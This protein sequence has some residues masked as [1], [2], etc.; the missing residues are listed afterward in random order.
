MTHI[1]H[2]AFPS[3][4][5]RTDVLRLYKQM[6]KK[7]PKHRK[8]IYFSGPLTSGGAKTIYLKPPKSELDSVDYIPLVIK[9]NALFFEIVALET[10]EFFSDHLITLPHHLGNRKDWHEFDYLR[11]WMYYIS[12]VTITLVEQFE[13]YLQTKEI[14]DLSIFNNYLAPRERRFE[15][16][17]KLLDVFMQYFSKNEYKSNPLS[18]MVNMPD[19][20][21]SLGSRFE[22]ELA[23]AFSIKREKIYFDRKHPHFASHIAKVSPWLETL[24]YTNPAV[25]SGNGTQLIHIK[26]I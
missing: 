9:H 3:N 1:K 20:E 6:H 11:F 2:T 21:Q 19:S 18:F 7:F 14:I 22:N 10:H 5:K 15:E 25:I 8:E 23:K 26:M 16:Y 13:T 12:G 17:K 4:V 24:T